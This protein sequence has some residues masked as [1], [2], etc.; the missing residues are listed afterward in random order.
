MINPALELRKCQRGALGQISIR[1]QNKSDSLV[2][3]CV[4]K[5]NQ[6]VSVVCRG[7][8]NQRI[9]TNLLKTSSGNTPVEKEKGLHVSDEIKEIFAT[10]MTNT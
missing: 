2:D 5:S 9:N 3:L 6:L 7:S 8:N 4:I 10:Y 1:F